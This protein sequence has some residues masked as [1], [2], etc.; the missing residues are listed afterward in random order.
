MTVINF[1]QFSQK[2]IALTEKASR[3]SDLNFVVGGRGREL[4]DFPCRSLIIFQF[5]EKSK[6]TESQHLEKRG[7][8]DEIARLLHLKYPFRLLEARK[9]SAAISPVCLRDRHLTDAPVTYQWLEAGCPAVN[10]K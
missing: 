3:R 5:T 1:K 8:I 4:Y 7:K 6:S 9:T 10:K 2:G